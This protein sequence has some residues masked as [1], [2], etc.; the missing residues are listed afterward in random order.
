MNDSASTVLNKAWEHL[1]EAE[2]RGPDLERMHADVLLVFALARMQEAWG[3]GT[4]LEMAQARIED[5]RARPVA[6]AKLQG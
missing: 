4:A 5:M 3:R 2:G 1:L 6:Y